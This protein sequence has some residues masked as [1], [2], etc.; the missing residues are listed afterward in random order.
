MIPPYVDRHS[1]SHFEYQLSQSL[2]SEKDWKCGND[3]HHTNLGILGGWVIPVL[4][5]AEEILQGDCNISIQ[6]S[7]SMIH[8]ILSQ[9]QRI[10][11][12]REHYDLGADGKW[13]K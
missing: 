13:Y 2:G 7:S 5:I 10:Y 3:Q 4:Q 9:R 8:R 12:Y 11:T 6:R 1:V